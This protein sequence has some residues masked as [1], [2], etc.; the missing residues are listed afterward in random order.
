MRLR[1]ATKALDCGKDVPCSIACS[2]ES[3]NLKPEWS[4]TLTPLSWYGLWE[5]EIITPAA[6]ASVRAR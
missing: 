1:D 2:V 6:N 3:G 4:S 5:A